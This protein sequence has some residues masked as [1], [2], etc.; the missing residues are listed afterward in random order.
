MLASSYI[1]SYK[2]TDIPDPN[3]QLSDTPTE[4]SE[5]QVQTSSEYILLTGYIN[6]IN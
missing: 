5:E 4:A 6:M 1:A 3:N 2:T